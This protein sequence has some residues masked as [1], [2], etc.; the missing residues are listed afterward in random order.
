QTISFL[1]SPAAVDLCRPEYETG[2]L[3]RFRENT[4]TYSTSIL[5]I[6]EELI[7]AVILSSITSHTLAL[8]TIRTIH[9][10]PYDLTDSKFIRDTGRETIR[11]ALRDAHI[12]DKEKIAKQ[13]E[14]P[15]C[16]TTALQIQAGR[17]IKEEYRVLWSSIK[18][19]SKAGLD[20]FSRRIQWQWLEAFSFINNRDRQAVGLLGLSHDVNELVELVWDHWNKLRRVELDDRKRRAFVTVLER[21]EGAELESKTDMVLA[22]AYKASLRTPII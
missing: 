11:Q 19:I 5:N 14:L 7:C 12:P 1:L 13:I 20:I 10:P 6:F 22:K 21:A 8:R 16:S 9:N 4:Q 2:D 17:E 3:L 18:G 15:K